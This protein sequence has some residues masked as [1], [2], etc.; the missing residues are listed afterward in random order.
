MQVFQLLQH[1]LSNERLRANEMRDRAG[2]QPKV[3]YKRVD[4]AIVGRDRSIISVSTTIRYVPQNY[5]LTMLG[6]SFSQIAGILI[7]KDKKLGVPE[8]DVIGH[9]L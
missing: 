6:G 4:P 1:V 5:L 8:P 7:S 9:F 2:G 3:N